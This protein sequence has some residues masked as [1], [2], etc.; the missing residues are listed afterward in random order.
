[1]KVK[2]DIAVPAFKESGA[3]TSMSEADG[4]FEIP[5][6]IDLVEKGEIVS[7]TIF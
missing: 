7:V 2:G 5:A 3:I 4:Y 6:D 1:V